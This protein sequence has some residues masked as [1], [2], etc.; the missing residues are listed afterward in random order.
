MS[1]EENI[2]LNQTVPA[3]NDDDDEQPAVDK[4]KK[5]LKDVVLE[6]LEEKGKGKD[7][8]LW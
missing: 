4:K 6:G 1:Q 3:A 7:C 2:K 5:T 8:W